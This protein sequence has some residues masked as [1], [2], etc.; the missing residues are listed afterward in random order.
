MPFDNQ[1]LPIARA[2]V[3]CKVLSAKG[4]ELSPAKIK[5]KVYLK[6]AFKTIILKTNSSL[7]IPQM[8]TLPGSEA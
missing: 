7:K 3:L 2:S 8:Y 5:T 6:Y 4:C 1:G